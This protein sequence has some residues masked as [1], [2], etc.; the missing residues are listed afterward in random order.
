MEYLLNVGLVIGIA[1]MAE[2]QYNVTLS[3]FSGGLVE[4]VFGITLDE[5]INRARLSAR[6][7]HEATEFTRQCNSVENQHV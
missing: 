7:W 2:G 5:A 1:K 4:T 6:A 3:T